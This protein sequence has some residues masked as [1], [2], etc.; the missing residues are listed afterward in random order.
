MVTVSS[1]LVET[2]SIKQQVRAGETV[3]SARAMDEPTMK[4]LY[5][6]NMSFDPN[7]ERAPISRKQKAEDPSCWAGY[8]LRLMLMLLYVL[9]MLC[10]LRYDEALRI[11][12]ANVHFESIPN[13]LYPFRIR[14]DLPFRK[15]HQHGG[16]LEIEWT[17]TKLTNCCK[18]ALHHSIFMPAPKSP[19]CVLFGCLQSGGFSR[20]GRRV[21][22]CSESA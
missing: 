8:G 22:M 17:G 6:F 5:E 10:L 15:T 14:L 12:W 11:T 9:S 16:E 19:G 21:V 20:V 2:N 18:K 4:R 1:V 13:S 7:A 3:T